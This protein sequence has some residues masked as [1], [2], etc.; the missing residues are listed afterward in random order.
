MLVAAAVD[1]EHLALIHSLGMR[2]TLV[3]PLI[4]RGHNLGAVTLVQG[5]LGRR[6]YELDLACARQLVATAAVGLDNARLFEQQRSI[7]QTLPAALLPHELPRRAGLADGRPPRASRCRG[8]SPRTAPGS[9]GG[10][11]LEWRI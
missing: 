7:A 9:D 3:A 4:V 5:E 10:S 1:A 11:T 2:S 8:W 6:F